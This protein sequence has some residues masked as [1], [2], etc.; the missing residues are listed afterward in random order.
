MTKHDRF[1]FLA[2]HLLSMSKPLPKFESYLNPEKDIIIN[3]ICA[4]FVDQ[5]ELFS[6]VL[7]KEL[8]LLQFY[9]SYGHSVCSYTIRLPPFQHQWTGSQTIS[10]LEDQVWGFCLVVQSWSTFACCGILVTFII[11]HNWIRTLS[12]W[13][14]GLNSHINS[15]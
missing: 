12:N 6:F 10:N 15:F 4:R 11:L 2:R 7:I 13:A 3:F 5:N 9:W 14:S 1:L 8:L